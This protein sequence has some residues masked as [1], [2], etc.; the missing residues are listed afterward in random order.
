[1]LAEVVVLVELK[2]ARFHALLRINWVAWRIEDQPFG[3]FPWLPL[4][5]GTCN[6]VRF[7]YIAPLSRAG[8]VISP[9]LTGD[10]SRMGVEEVPLVTFLQSL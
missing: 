6:H 4:S 1:V 3:F 7:R 5:S 8:Y 10:L 2:T 9:F